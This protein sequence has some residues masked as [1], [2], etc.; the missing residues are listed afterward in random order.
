MII[1]GQQYNKV[2]EKTVNG[3]VY[4]LFRSDADKAGHG[5]D[6]TIAISYPEKQSLDKHE[7]S[8]IGKTKNKKVNHKELKVN[9][10][11]DWAIIHTKL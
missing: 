11:T 6:D 1:N 4:L 9:A 3:T 8:L 10:Q 7:I 2:N 5:L